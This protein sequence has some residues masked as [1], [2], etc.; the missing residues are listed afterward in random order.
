MADKKQQAN[1]PLNR[2]DRS[3]QQMVRELKDA[4]VKQKWRYRLRPSGLPACQWLQMLAEVHDDEDLPTEDFG[5]LR[6]YYTNVGTVVHTV[7]QR[8]LGRLGYLFGKF[9]CDRCKTVV[10]HQGWPPACAK[11]CKAPTWTYEEIELL[12]ADP[13]GEF[14]SAHCDGLIRF[15]WMNDGE[16][17]LV[18]FKTCSLATVPKPEEGFS[19]PR[20]MKYLVQ[21]NIYRHLLERLDVNIIGTGFIMVPRDSPARTT[22]ILYDQSETNGPVFHDTI[23]QWRKAKKAAAGN[24]ATG[25]KRTCQTKLDNPECPF[26]SI[27]FDRR[28]VEDVFVKRHGKLPILPEEF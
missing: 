17:Y 20:H 5:F 15:S 24:D 14:T 2:G 8:W 6:D 1:R 12:E 9:R 22:C 28:A 25:I 19:S 23:E 16:Y 3:F 7:F 26:N 11:G 4:S 21:L 18:D 27:C 10:W 13:T